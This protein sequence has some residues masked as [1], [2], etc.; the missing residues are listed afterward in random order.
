MTLN[1]SG[2]VDIVDIGTVYHELILGYTPIDRLQE[3]ITYDVTQALLSEEYAG[4]EVLTADDL[5]NIYETIG[6]EIICGTA[7]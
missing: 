3:L 7:I 6:Y 1:T 2:I 4:E 5:A